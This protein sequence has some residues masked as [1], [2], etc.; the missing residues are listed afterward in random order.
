MFLIGLFTGLVAVIID[1][2]VEYISE[3]KY[4]YITKR[5]IFLLEVYLI[6]T[7][8]NFSNDSGNFKSN[9]METFTCL[10]IFKLFFENYSKL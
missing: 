2:L 3:I 1:T 4:S 9:L 7:L 5:K 8:I 6:I 10:D